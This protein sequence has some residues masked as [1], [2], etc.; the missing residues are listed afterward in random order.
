MAKNSGWKQAP[1]INVVAQVQFDDD[2]T[3][4][5]QMAQ[6]QAA[7][8]AEGYTGTEEFVEELQ[9]V[10][11]NSTA[12]STRS[13]R[14]FYDGE[15]RNVVTVARNE[16]RYSTSNY[17]SFEEFLIQFETCIKA[18]GDVGGLVRRIGLR[19]MD[20]L[21]GTPELPTK[22]QM[23]SSFSNFELDGQDG[24]QMMFTAR[25]ASSQE[26]R[27]VFRVLG[28]IGAAQHLNQFAGRRPYIPRLNAK[29][30]PSSTHDWL[31]LDIDVFE[32]WN[33]TVPNERPKVEAAPSILQRFHEQA[34]EIFKRSLSEN[35]IK[36]YKG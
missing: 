24:S 26:Q 29:S 3:V 4:E 32:T 13:L 11:P 20:L 1:V 33:A 8:R 22:S 31:V 19:Y 18:V 7:L 2:L 9:I 35:A 12:I 27:V 6:I 21:E 34:S 5:Q 14:E 15:A 23:H 17:T 36:Y 30:T 10:Q 28:G 25:E 16:L